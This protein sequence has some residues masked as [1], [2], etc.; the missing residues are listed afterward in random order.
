MFHLHTVAC[1][2]SKISSTLFDFRQFFM[3]S[4]DGSSPVAALK[5]PN[6]VNN[7]RVSSNTRSLV[8]HAAITEPLN[9]MACLK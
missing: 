1:T 6:F 9:W 7:V 2:A 8:A 5:Q 3:S 4:E